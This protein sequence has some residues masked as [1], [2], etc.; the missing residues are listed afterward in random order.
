M[1]IMEWDL[2]SGKKLISLEGHNGDVAALRCDTLRSK[3][4]C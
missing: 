1:K 4:Q 3:C 2:A